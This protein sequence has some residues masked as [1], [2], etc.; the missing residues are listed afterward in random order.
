M[1]LQ[2]PFTLRE[3][4]TLKRLCDRAVEDPMDEI[5]LQ[6]TAQVTDSLETFERLARKNDRDET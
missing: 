5:E 6:V 1:K 4:R 3:L 2:V